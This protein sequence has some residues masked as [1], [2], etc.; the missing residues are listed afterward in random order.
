MG[1]NL[2]LENAPHDLGVSATGRIMR[3]VCLTLIPAFIAHLYFY[4]WGIL[5]TLLLCI[6]SCLTVEGIIL[7]LRN[8]S[9]NR[10]WRDSSA[11]VTAVLLSFALP[12][13]LP[14]YLTVIGC[15][16]AIAIVKHSFGGL[17]QNIFNPAMGGF[18]FL[19]VSSPIAMTEY[20]DAV[21]ANWSNLTVARASAII[22]NVNKEEA[23]K[24][25]HQSIKE[26]VK[27]R[28]NL[29]EQLIVADAFTGS[30]FLV[31]AM[32][33]RPEHKVDSY[34]EEHMNSILEYSFLAHL[35]T[36]LCFILGG[37]YLILKQIADYRIPLGF[38]GTILIGSSICYYI[39]PELFLPPFYHVAF[40]ATLLGA[41]Y[42][43]T[44]PVTAV[45]KPVGAYSFGITVGLIFIVIRNFGGYPDAVAFSVLIGNSVAPLISILTKRRDFGDGSKEGALYE[46]Q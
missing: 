21:P 3:T 25:T 35:I 32:H 37:G 13:L 41:F 4:G 39:S 24:E 38:L 8:H 27:A 5:V 16:F 12:P 46:K 1:T 22:F 6:A 23:L 42:I 18:V 34:V 17:G 15:I 2:S 40:G 43:L 33:Q 31:D 14:W 10:L 30:T 36:G 26:S 28:S 45:S 9:L 29:G 11:L 19:L 20:V 7:K 44:D